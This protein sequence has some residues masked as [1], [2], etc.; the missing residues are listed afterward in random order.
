[1]IDDGS[2][3]STIVKTLFLVCV[4]VCVWARNKDLASHACPP[5]Q[6]LYRPVCLFPVP[7]YALKVIFFHS[8]YLVCL[9]LSVGPCRLN[10]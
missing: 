8:F 3:V 7:T 1:M 6:L 5:T 4:C 2:E 10:K 9:R